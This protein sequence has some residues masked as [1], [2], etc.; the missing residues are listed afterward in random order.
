MPVRSDISEATVFAAIH[1]VLARGDVPTQAAVQKEVGRGSYPVIAGYIA[2]WFEQN[3][4]ALASDNPSPGAAPL[5]LRQQLEEVTRLAA[6]E[7]NE[8][9]RKRAEALGIRETALDARAKGLD[10]READLIEAERRQME[11][12]LAQVDLVETLKA[13][14]INAIAAKDETDGKLAD[15]QAALSTSQATCAELRLSLTKAEGALADM[16]LS[17]DKCLESASR[18]GEARDQLAA[19]CARLREELKKTERRAEELCTEAADARSTSAHMS[20][21]TGAIRETLRTTSERLTQALERAAAGEAVAVELRNAVN[22]AELRAHD[23]TSR[24]QE[25]SESAASL[26]LALAKAHL[27][28]EQLQAENHT[29]QSETATL[30]TERD[31]VLATI[32]T[33]VP[34]MERLEARLAGRST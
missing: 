18:T 14:R 28:A 31:E 34:L 20:A 25:L 8:A 26:Q 33:A 32:A 2:R 6:Q 23:A 16:K 4:P 11:R 1:R 5:S 27:R 30:K 10:A 24:S 12:E 19:E 29:L 9:E 13:D 21:E 17:M 15:S 3:G 22:E 7:I